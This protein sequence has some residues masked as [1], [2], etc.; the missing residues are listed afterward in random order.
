M[1]K[2]LIL[3][4]TFIF[5]SMFWCNFVYAWGGSSSLDD[6]FEKANDYQLVNN[7][8]EDK[9]VEWWVKKTMKLMLKL[10]IIIW[11]AVFLYGGIRFL[12]SMWDDSKA[13]KTRDTLIVSA[14]W[15]IIA[16]GAWAILQV[17]LS[18][19]TTIKFWW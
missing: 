2:R 15:F 6:A 18:I 11:I 13:K 17:I 4:L 19:W 9:D 12:L 1:L 16:F 5:Y 8:I 10:T 3:L 7:S 14:I